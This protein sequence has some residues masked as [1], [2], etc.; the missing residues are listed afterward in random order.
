MWLLFGTSLISSCQQKNTTEQTDSAANPALNIFEGQQGKINIAGGTAHIPVMK[1]AAKDIM[2]ANP[3]IRITIAG[4]GSGVGAQ[5]AAQGLADIGNTGRPLKPGEQSLGLISHPFAIDGVAIIIH[6]DNPV[7]ALSKSQIEAIY[8]GILTN[9]KSVG[10][11]DKKIHVFTRD[12]ASG[13]RSV[14]IK[15]LLAPSSIMNSANVTTSN[16]G[17]KTAVSQD[18]AAIGYCSIGYID[19]TVKAPLY[20]GI[21]PSNATCVSGEYPVM[22]R[23]YM[24]TLAEP[25]GLTKVFIEFIQ[26]KDAESYILSSGYI[27]I[28]GNK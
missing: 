8:A 12:E 18:S 19:D 11:A 2:T 5:Q 1:K 25:E 10:G 15:K 17:M 23:L 16:G 3:K 13:T 26:S 21:T 4:G 7:R 27:P 24:N 20:E 9:W 22:R 14:F 6:P 28:H